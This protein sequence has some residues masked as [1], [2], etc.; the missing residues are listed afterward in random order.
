MDQCNCR[1]IL[2]SKVVKFLKFHTRKQNSFLNPVC[3]INVVSKPCFEIMWDIS[4]SNAI[5]PPFEY[6]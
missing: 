4:R 5:V 3:E 1:S 2:K 6:L